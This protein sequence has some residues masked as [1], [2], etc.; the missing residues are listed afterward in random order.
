MTVGV[1]ATVASPGVSHPLAHRAW[2]ALIAAAAASDNNAMDEI[3]DIPCSRGVLRLRP[4]RD[5]DLEFRFRLFCNFRPELAL[6]PLEPAARDQ[7]MQLQFRA[8]TMSYRAR[9][10]QARFD[11]IE[12]D[13][14][15]I[16]RIVVDRWARRLHRRIGGDAAISQP[17]HRQHDHACSHA[18]GRTRRPLGVPDGFHDQRSVAAALSAPRLRDGRS[19]PDPHRARMAGVTCGG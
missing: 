6:L 1:N 3:V 14:V 13:G 19:R 4:E 9:F 2:P 8:Q 17:R 7:L 11:I 5:E 18:G 15:A 12:L 16:G 10:S